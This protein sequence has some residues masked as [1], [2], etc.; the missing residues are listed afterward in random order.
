MIPIFPQGLADWNKIRAV[1]EAVAVPVFANGNVLFHS[2]IEAC[3]KATGADAVMSAETQLYNPAIFVRPSPS[4]FRVGLPPPSPHVLHVQGFVVLTC[5]HLFFILQ[6]SI[7][8]I[9][10]RVSD[11]CSRALNGHPI[12]CGLVHGE[13]G[14]IRDRPLIV[15]LCAND[16][17]LILWRVLGCRVSHEEDILVVF[18]RTNGSR[19]LISLQYRP[20]TYSGVAAFLEASKHRGRHSSGSTHHSCLC[21]KAT[22]HTP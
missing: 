5:C 13:E 9:L 17:K 10:G 7:E 19:L 15:Q 18:C 22:F 8:C 4:P 11:G 6:T 3:L 14:G 16:P 21:R 12:S 2:D 1:K 20:T